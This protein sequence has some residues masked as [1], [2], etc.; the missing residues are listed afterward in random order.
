MKMLLMILIVGGI[1]F[2]GFGSIV[3]SCAIG[4][5]KLE[6]MRELDQGEVK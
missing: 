3:I 5:A 6:K 2:L 1:L 4:G